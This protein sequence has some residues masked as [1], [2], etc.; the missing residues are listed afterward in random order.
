MANFTR[1]V[2]NTPPAKADAALRAY[3]IL[4]LNLGFSGG[5]IMHYALVDTAFSLDAHH[6]GSVDQSLNWATVATDSASSIAAANKLTTVLKAHLADGS[7]SH[8]E[9]DTDSVAITAPVA[10]DDASCTT[11]LLQV[12]ATLN[13][14]IF[15]AAPHR[16]LP[17]VIEA[18]F[19]VPS[20]LASNIVCV[21]EC[22]LVYKQHF[23][24]A[25]ETLIL[26]TT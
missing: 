25:A 9:A 5:A 22:L 1:T 6:P 24:A 3:Q 21:T 26:G 4:I 14:H 18:V 12:K 10:T 19:S 7:Y 23:Y 16:A 20:D 17:P 15:D 11:L 2:Q 13:A 8:S